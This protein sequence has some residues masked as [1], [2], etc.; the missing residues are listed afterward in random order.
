MPGL[1][2]IPE[3]FPMSRRRPT[4]AVAALAVAF[5]A[6]LLPPARADGRL[7]VGG[8]RN[9]PRGHHRDHGSI[10]CPPAV[11]HSSGPAAT[12][13]YPPTAS[14]PNRPAAIVAT[15]GGRRGAAIRIEGTP[16]P[17]PQAAAAPPASTTSSDA[18]SLKTANH[19]FARMAAQGDIAFRYPAEGCYARTHL[20]V[21][22][23][24]A[25]GLRPRKVWS[26]ARDEQLYVRT[27]HAPEGFVEWGYHVAPT[28]RVRAG[29]GTRDMVIDPSLFDR[30]VTIARW[31]EA[32]RK[33]A[34]SPTPHT[35][36]TRIGQAPTRADGERAPGTGY[37]P[38]S[39]PKGDLDA[40]SSKLM[41]K[42]KPLEPR[43]RAAPQIA[44]R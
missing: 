20:M 43:R 2:P 41:S 1:D 28:L 22:R 13:I 12:M 37:W 4:P 42:Y 38:A 35:C 5:L 30:P 25:M 21:K 39:D 18:V 32:Q 6:V 33:D 7:R 34:T 19:A 23:L 27:E 3:G 8:N 11:T 26:F 36:V 17:L 14:S 40:F 9:A 29:G 31:V 16:P 24:Q 44:S 10:A 15:Y